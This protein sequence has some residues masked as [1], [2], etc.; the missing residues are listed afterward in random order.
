[1]GEDDALE[2]PLVFHPEG[3]ITYL[4]N[5]QTVPRFLVYPIV[6]TM[7]A[8]EKVEILLHRLR[9]ASLLGVSRDGVGWSRLASGDYLFK[10]HAGCRCSSSDSKR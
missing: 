9:G 3:S 4:A 1:M 10:I 2:Q 8:G 7:G 6:N 5:D